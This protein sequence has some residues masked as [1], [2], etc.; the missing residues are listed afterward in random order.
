MLR[1]WVSH[2]LHPFYKTHAAPPLHS[3][4][5]SLTSLQDYCVK[6]QLCQSWAATDEVTAQTRDSHPPAQF[7][8]DIQEDTTDKDGWKESPRSDK[9]K[10]TCCAHGEPLLSPLIAPYVLPP[11]CLPLFVPLPWASSG[12]VSANLSSAGIR[13]ITLMIAVPPRSSRPTSG[14]NLT[15]LL[16]VR[17]I[18]CLCPERR[19]FI[20]PLVHRLSLLLPPS[21]VSNPFSL[22]A[23]QEP[24]ASHL[25]WVVT[26]HILEL[27]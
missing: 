24:Q 23:A 11:P 19:H 25:V 16:F 8:T 12:T 3:S 6:P 7:D 4:A 15:H 20:S 14:T 18:Y 27:L 9:S 26:N 17:P 13:F 1:T 22:L 10:L 21:I 2:L 5:F